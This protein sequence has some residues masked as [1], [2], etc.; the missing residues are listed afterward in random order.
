MNS[1][2]LTFT[3][4]QMGVGTSSP[5]STL[6]SGGS[7]AASIRSTSTN[8]TLTAADFT[9]IMYNQNLLITLPAPSSCPGRIYILK[10]LSTGEN[11]TSVSF[12]TDNGSTDNRIRN[13]RIYWLQSDGTN[14]QQIVKD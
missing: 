11:N 2:N 3:N 8:T 9:L 10:N 6:Q 13:N 14:W 7:F 5:T 4:G 1:R 12:I